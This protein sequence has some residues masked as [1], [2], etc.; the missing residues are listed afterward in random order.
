MESFMLKWYLDKDQSML[1]IEF[2]IWGTTH[3][4][5]KYGGTVT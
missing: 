4:M 1:K 3:N 5:L 2:Q